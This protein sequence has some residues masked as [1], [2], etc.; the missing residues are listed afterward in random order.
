MS[1]APIRVDFRQIYWSANPDTAVAYVE[2]DCDPNTQYVL[3]YDFDNDIISCNHLCNGYN[4]KHIE[5]VAESLLGLYV[6][7]NRVESF[8]FYLNMD[9]IPAYGF[10]DNMFIE[11]RESGKPK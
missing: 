7:N 9:K 2:E 3:V 6:L 11:A 1:K 5:E 4:R 8:M 10:I